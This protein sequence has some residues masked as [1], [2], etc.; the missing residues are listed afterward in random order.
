MPFDKNVADI[1]WTHA[2]LATYSD[3]IRNYILLNVVF[4]VFVHFWHMNW[5]NVHVDRCVVLW[6]RHVLHISTFACNKIRQ[7]ARQA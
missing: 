1:F 7:T 3:K 6:S 2:K 4:P 5:K